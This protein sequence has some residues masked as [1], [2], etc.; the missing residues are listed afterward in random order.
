LSTKFIS[1]YSG[2]LCVI[3]KKA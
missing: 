1:D 2:I 3:S